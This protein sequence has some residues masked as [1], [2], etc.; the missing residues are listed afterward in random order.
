MKSDSRARISLF[1]L[2]II[3]AFSLIVANPFVL[4]QDPDPDP[5]PAPDPEPD[6]DPAPDP[7]PTPDP[8][9]DP[10]PAPD[11]DPEPTT[12]P[13]P[14][15]TTEPDPDSNVDPGQEPPPEPTT[16]PTQD[17]GDPDSVTDPS[18]DPETL[19]PDEP[20]PEPTPDDDP[21]QT[22]E[23]RTDADGCMVT[24]CINGDHSRYCPDMPGEPEEHVCQDI[25]A[26][27]PP[28]CGEGMYMVDEFDDRGCHTGWRCESSEGPIDTMWCPTEN[29]CPD[30]SKPCYIDYDA[31]E[32]I[33]KTCPPPEGCWNE[34]DPN[35]GYER[36][37]CGN[38]QQN[39]PPIDV[40][41]EIKCKQEGGAPVRKTNHAGCD[42]I[43]CEFWNDENRSNN[44]FV[45]SGQCPS[46]EDVDRHIR[47]CQE[48]GMRGFKVE[49]GGCKIGRCESEEHEFC[50]EITWE[51]RDAMKRKCSEMD[52]AVIER[53]DNNGCM[54]LKCGGEDE[55]MWLPEEAYRRCNQDGGELIVEEDHRGCV[56]WHN[57]VRRGDDR[58]VY[59][60]DID[61]VPESDVLLSIA[62]KLED[63]KM[64]FNEL[65]DKSMDIANFY[66]SSGSSEAE[67]FRRV[68][69]MFKSAMGTVDEIKLKIRDRMDY[70]SVGDI[71]EFKHDIKYI[72]EV[73][74][75][76]IVF[77]MLSSSDDVRGYI[78]QEPGLEMTPDDVG[79]C[80]YD[81][82]CFD[83]SLRICQPTMFRPDNE[84]N[85]EIVGVEGDRCK[86]IVKALQGPQGMDMSMTCL[87]PDY[88]MGMRGPED[89]IPHCQGPMADF[90]KANP[91]YVNKGPSGGEGTGRLPPSG[92]P[93]G[94]TTKLECDEYCARQENFNE[95]RQ[96]VEKMEQDNRERYGSGPGDY[97]PRYDDRLDGG[98]DFGKEGEQ[99][100]DQTP[101][102]GCLNNGLC[103]PGE[104]RDCPDC[105]GGRG[106]E[107]FMI[108][109]R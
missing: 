80:G 95:C 51:T 10:D 30:G 8:E 91:E 68:S 36:Y 83:R 73:I 38:D 54:F 59:Y 84:V 87:F 74:L 82:A 39:C 12:K 19:P 20:P 3:V 62:F 100:G 61:R 16:D 106:S 86:L 69:G 23:T 9:P 29:T 109:R 50:R 99:F 4:A 2:I 45:G 67:R 44:P 102:S 31:E 25:S 15:P 97:E 101:C 28:N 63:L 22:C 21:T 40:D 104:C 57:C 75:K 42:Y 96:F 92:G 56:V 14:E 88:S 47:S 37:V 26:I 66:A 58:D 18:Q 77:V 76:D 71:E 48:M 24:T 35:T 41:K 52:T 34:V 49:E 93:G 94:C 70:L 107:G 7:E 6:P 53:F 90:L 11:P 1:L 79:G 105:M 33:C 27:D 89:M 13:D 17:P 98:R 43:V 85:I 60:E 72:K 108:W 65:S 64:K 81:G 32:C 55:C 103:D 46:E 78:E 5:D